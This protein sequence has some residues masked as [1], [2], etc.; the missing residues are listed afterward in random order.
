M[1]P[2]RSR[3]AGQLRNAIRPLMTSRVDVRKGDL[4]LRRNAQSFPNGELWMPMNPRLAALKSRGG[5]HDHP[6]GK[7]P[8]DDLQSDGQPVLGPARGN[9]CSRLAR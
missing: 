6:V 5:G 9:T 3:T 4:L 8:P 2:A 1:I 7:P